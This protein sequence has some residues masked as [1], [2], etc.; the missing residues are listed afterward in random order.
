MLVY[1]NPKAAEQFIEELSKM[2][3]YILQLN[4]TYLV[5]LKEELEFIQSYIYLQKI[6]HQGSLQ[7]YTKVNAHSLNQL[8]PPLTL[9]LLVENAI[10]HNAIAKDTPLHI[11][12]STQNG[13]LY[14]KNPIQP[15]LE[16]EIPSTKVG[17]KNLLEKYKILDLSLIHI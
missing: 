8:I 16:N 1:K 4:E 5:P 12:L 10:K 7:F 14:L 9:E 6:R 2:Y 13:H 17:L 11:K 3:R 15:R